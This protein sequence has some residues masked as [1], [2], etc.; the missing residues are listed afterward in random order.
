M[1]HSNPPAPRK[2]DDRRAALI[3][4]LADHVLAHGLTASSLRPLAQA[5]GTSDRMLLYYFKD[6]AE[7]IGATLDCIAVRMMA[8]MAPPAVAQPQPLAVLR[9]QL[10]ATVRDPQF[11]P[12]LRVWLEM[13]SRAAHGD[14]LYRSVG[15]RIGRAF[16]AW[17]EAQLATADPAARRAEAAQLLVMTEGLVLITSLGLDEVAALAV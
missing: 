13:A 12:Y 3:D 6:K 7:I 8:A 15:E 9:A 5:A 10:A 2:A 11:W 14:L 1:P 17:G 4:R 16:L